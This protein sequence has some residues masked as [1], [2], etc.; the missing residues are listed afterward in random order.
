MWGSTSTYKLAI[1]ILLLCTAC[2]SPALP[3]ASA[4]DVGSATA[5]ADAIAPEDANAAA[6]DGG[7]TDVENDATNTG[8]ISQTADAGDGA[9]AVKYPFKIELLADPH[10]NRETS[11]A[12]VVFKAHFQTAI[13][14]VNAANV[15]L[16][17]VAGDLSQASGPKEFID[18]KRYTQ[19]FKAPVWYVPGNHDV[20]NK[21]A[22]GP[23]N[24]ATPA[25]SAVYEKAMGPSWFSKVHGGIRIIGIN[26]A[27]L[28]SGFESEKL[29]WQFL[30]EELSGPSP[31]PTF[32]LTHYPLFVQDLLEPGGIYWNIE[33][34]AR[35]RLYALLQR[36]GAKGVL[37]GHLHHTMFNRREGIVFVG[38]PPISFGLPEGQQPE[39]WVL[40]TLLENGQMVEK[41]QN[42][43]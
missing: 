34:I 26:S 31:Q 39:G 3:P 15:D 1:V 17:L 2:T 24:I 41:V 20:G 18:F 22:M 29:M 6:S 5:S 36:A 23:T 28:G 14:Q 10:V 42:L 33:P 37:S 19:S 40:L 11:G 4:P 43:Q 25:R 7:S 9:V 8:E 38:A 30:E 16:V 32:V 27:I 13:A 12:D 21:V 35:K